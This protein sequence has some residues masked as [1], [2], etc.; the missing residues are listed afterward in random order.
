MLILQFYGKCAP[1][2]FLDC[3][4]S[5]GQLRDSNEITFVNE[6]EM[7]IGAGIKFIGPEFIISD[8]VI[9]LKVCFFALKHLLD[10]S[11]DIYL[12]IIF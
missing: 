8:K 11:Y 3:I 5:L 9:P 4:K 7:T 12:K 6:L 2:I 1:S 10:K